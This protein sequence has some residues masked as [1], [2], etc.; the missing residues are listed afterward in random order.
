MKTTID[1]AGRVVIPAPIRARM[2]LKAG[3]EL[4]VEVQDF[5][6][7]LVR[8]VSRPKLVRENK[9]LIARPT[10]P[11]EQ[12]TRLDVAALVREERERWPW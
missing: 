11:P 2:G 8:R 5:S 3:T 4:D 12:W 6:I 1:K 9:R 10:A 7:R